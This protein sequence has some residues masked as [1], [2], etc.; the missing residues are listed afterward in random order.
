M[1]YE[2]SCLRC[3]FQAGVLDKPG[4]DGTSNPALVAQLQA[5]IQVSLNGTVKLVFIFCIMWRSN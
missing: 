1:M 5:E 2:D 3:N 4:V